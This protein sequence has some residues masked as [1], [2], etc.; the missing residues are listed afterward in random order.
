MEYEVQ[1]KVSML[2]V[3]SSTWTVNGPLRGVRTVRSR[4]VRITT[5]PLSLS[6]DACLQ[7]DRYVSSSEDE[8][9]DMDWKISCL[10]NFN[11]SLLPS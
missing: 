2:D 7:G 8:N 5:A 3:G 4:A 10:D 11:I 9:V 6:Q 1:A